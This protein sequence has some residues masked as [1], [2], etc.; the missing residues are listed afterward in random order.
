MMNKYFFSSDN[1]YLQDKMKTEEFKY[2]EKLLDLRYELGLNFKEVADILNL[3][4][5]EYIDY[6]Y[7]E[8]NIS[9]EDYIK[10]IEKLENYKLKEE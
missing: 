9:K 2:S 5:D 6:E 4:V 10:A 1:K 8:S 7:G 3:K